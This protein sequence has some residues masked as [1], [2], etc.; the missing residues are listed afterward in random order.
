MSYNVIMNFFNANQQISK[1]AF[2]QAAEKTAMQYLKRQGLRL[3]EQNFHCR[4]GEID[5]IMCDGPTWVFIEVRCRE[6]NAQVSATESITPS[7]VE[8][9]VKR[10]NI[11]QRALKKCLIVASMLLR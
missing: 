11:L 9:F 4:F 1:R 10:L 7:K 8:K 3:K 5:L 2:G 6:A